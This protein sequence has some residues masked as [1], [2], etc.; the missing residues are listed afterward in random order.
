VTIGTGC[1]YPAAVKTVANQF[2]GARLSWKGY[3]ETTPNYVFIT[4]NLCNDGH[5][6]PCVDSAPGGLVQADGFLRRWVPVIRGSPAFASDGLLI[7]ALGYAGDQQLK[8]FGA[9]IFGKQ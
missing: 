3:V 9:D 8:T 6:S 5:D 4:P 2:H 7:I 1:V